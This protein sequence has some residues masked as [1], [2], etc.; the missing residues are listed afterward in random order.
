MKRITVAVT[1]SMTAEQQQRALE[2][3]PNF[4]RLIHPLNRVL[5]YDVRETF[6]M[7]RSNQT[8]VLMLVKQHQ[9]HHRVALRHERGR[10]AKVLLPVSS[11]IELGRL[12]DMREA[13]A[14]ERQVS[15]RARALRELS[16]L[17]T[18]TLTVLT[19]S[20]DGWKATGAWRPVLKSLAH[21]GLARQ[22]ERRWYPA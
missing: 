14:Y 12:L 7:L 18:E 17:Q 4:R 5:V 8:T 9:V 1:R 16:A 6:R 15:P 2:R 20:P 22:V 21:R 11:V 10:Y 13:A 19:A 3:L